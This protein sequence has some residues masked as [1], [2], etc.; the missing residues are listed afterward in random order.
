MEVIKNEYAKK[1]ATLNLDAVIQE[2]AAAMQLPNETLRGLIDRMLDV[3]L[4]ELIKET[5]DDP[6]IGSHI[7]QMRWEVY[8]SGNLRRNFLTYDY[9]VVISRGLQL[10]DTYISIPVSPRKLFLAANPK[11]R[12]EKLWEMAQSDVVRAANFEIV[13]QARKYVYATDELQI[14]YVEK[15]LRKEV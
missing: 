8:E 10:E 12:I 5:M 7:N 15:H 13:K 11:C 9:P 3:H 14:N 2:N 6:E 1:A 4:G